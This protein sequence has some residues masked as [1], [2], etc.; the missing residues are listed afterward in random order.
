[1][2]PHPPFGHRPPGVRKGGSGHAEG[3]RDIGTGVSGSSRSALGPF[4]FLPDVL[5]HS[6]F[7]SVGTVKSDEKT[8]VV[9]PP[10]AG[11]IVPER[12]RMARGS[13]WRLLRVY[14]SEADQS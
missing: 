4:V 9:F 1:M 3:P 7:A 14:T 11:L 12:S 5:D 6:G 13:P 2:P 8:S 10:L